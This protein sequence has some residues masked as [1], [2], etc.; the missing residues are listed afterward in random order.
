MR[1]TKKIIILIIK[2]GKT[3][4]FLELQDREIFL[5]NYM[6]LSLMFCSLHTMAKPD[7]FLNKLSLSK[8]IPDIQ[9]NP[10]VHFLK[11]DFCI[12]S[13]LL[14]HYSDFEFWQ[15]IVVLPQCAQWFIQS[16]RLSDFLWT[17][18]ALLCYSIRS[19][20]FTL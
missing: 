2:K 15:K 5:W 6:C 18:A 17:H 7:F 20:F 11:S 3:R 12:K 10:G 1:K 8:M 14:E 9:V 13:H 16:A 19:F 4:Q